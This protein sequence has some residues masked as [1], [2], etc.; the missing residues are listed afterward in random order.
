MAFLDSGDGALPRNSVLRHQIIAR[1]VA[2]EAYGRGIDNDLAAARL[3]KMVDDCA[4]DLFL[5]WGAQEEMAVLV[6]L[7]EIGL[8]DAAG[9][10]AQIPQWLE[11][12]M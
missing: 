10:P 1:A 3:G 11:R 4:L 2:F 7:E 12:Q 6:F 9:M 8:K 5:L